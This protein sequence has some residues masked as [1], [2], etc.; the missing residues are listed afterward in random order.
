MQIV[1]SQVADQAAS[2]DYGY[3]LVS[4]R[5][6]VVGMVV[7]VDTPEYN[8]QAKWVGLW[9]RMGWDSFVGYNKYAVGKG[10]GVGGIGLD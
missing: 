7:V 5:Y 6:E 10:F 9:A 1:F 4:G 2:E 8:C 3:G